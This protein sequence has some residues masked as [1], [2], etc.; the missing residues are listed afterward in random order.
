MKKFRLMWIVY[1][2]M[3]LLSVG[4]ALASVTQ[5]DLLDGL[6]NYWDGSFSSTT[7]I[8][9]HGENN[10]TASNNRVFNTDGKIG[11][12]FDFTKGNDNIVF[13]NVGAY[14]T[15]SFWVYLPESVRRN[16][17]TKNSEILLSTA[18]SADTA[19]Y[20]GSASSLVSNAIFY[21]T[22]SSSGG[23]ANYWDFADFGFASDEALEIG[24]HFF[25]LRWDGSNYQLS[26]NGSDFVDRK[27]RD[28]FTD[29]KRDLTNFYLGQIVSTY[30]N[31]LIDEIAVYNRS[32][33]SSE[34]SALYNDGD[35]FQYPFSTSTNFSVSVVDEY[36]G[37]VVNNVSVVVDGVTYTNETGNT[38]TTNILTNDTS[39]YL[40][41][42]SANNYFS[43]NYSAVNVS[44]TL[45]AELYSAIINFTAQELFTNNTLTGFFVFDRNKT[46]LDTNTVYTAL[47]SSTGSTFQLARNIT[48]YTGEFVDNLKITHSSNSVSGTDRCSEVYA[49]FFYADGTTYTSTTDKVCSTTYAD[50]TI[51]MSERAQKNISYIEIWNRNI[52]NSYAG[53]ITNVVLSTYDQALA[54]TETNNFM[55]AGNFSMFFLYEGYFIKDFE[56]NISYLDEKNISVG[57]LSDAVLTVNVRKKVGN[58]SIDYFEGWLYNADYNYN[59]SFGGDNGSISFDLKKDLNYTL[60]IEADGYAITEENTV[61][62]DL[63]E[64]SYTEWFYLYQENSIDI[65]F[66]DDVTKALITENIT[67]ELISTDASYSYNTTSG[68]L[69]LTLL[70]PEDYIMR[71]SSANYTESFYRFEVSDQSYSTLTLYM[72]KNTS[73]DVL[74]VTVIDESAKP[75]EG[76]VVK[77][78]KYDLATNSYLVQ[79]VIATNVVGEVRFNVRKNEE[80]YRFIVEDTNGV[81]VRMTNPNYITA[82]SLTIQVVTTGLIAGEFFDLY[83][84]TSTI[85][86][87]NLTNNFRLEYN[88]ASNVGSNYCFKVS[89]LSN[90]KTLLDETCTTSTSGV[91]LLNI[92]VVNNTIYEA[93]F[94]VT[95]NPNL[96]IESFILDTKVFFDT[97][98]FGL[99]IQIFLTI[100]FAMAFFISPVFG[101]IMTP[102]SLLLGRILELNMLSYTVIVP[103]IFV[104]FIMAYILKR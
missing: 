16:V 56:A 29:T 62:I 103:L 54:L 24:W 5:S 7:A 69:N 74:T 81:M 32:L 40:V 90:K 35:G 92:A 25:A 68:M 80:F 83:G 1:V 47:V 55:T 30:G 15:M 77:S 76:Y 12:G 33:N 42:I 31:L 75:I 10:G 13:G 18:N 37:A 2:L 6:I 3:L 4:G 82:D 36:S 70:V 51:N 85:T 46:Y 86:F 78:L 41:Q 95:I 73:S 97:E 63:N 100:F 72:I 64:S 20:I 61:T 52:H 17:G 8:D 91:I 98:E 19:M 101:A 79:E 57:E 28:V 99:F 23:T 34:I 87:N 38:V 39:T 26:Y 65:E 94:Y 49:K 14:S 27:K 45:N 67:L 58:T 50:F 59:L 104:G 71:Y 89:T 60:Y 93:E 88:D 48:T 43:K 102:M 11:K 84:I 44:N 96:I 21:M 9:I 53:R 22:V 66:R